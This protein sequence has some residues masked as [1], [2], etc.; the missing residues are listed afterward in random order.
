MA[1]RTNLPTGGFVLCG[2]GSLTDPVLRLA[3]QQTETRYQGP[4]EILTLAG[5]VTADGAHLHAS[6]ASSRGEVFGG[7]VPFGN[8]VRTTAEVL[9]VAT[10]T[11]SLSRE[12]DGRTGFAELVTAR[13]PP[14]QVGAT[15]PNCPSTPS[16][17]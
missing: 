11:W 13:R 3:G 15:S 8:Q 4:F 5:S 12:L 7:H 1:C 16:P 6:I 17:D 14:E 10:E 9:I 2:I